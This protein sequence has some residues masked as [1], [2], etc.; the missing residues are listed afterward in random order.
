MTDPRRAIPR[1]DALL[2]APEFVD[3]AGRLGSTA[4]KSAIRSAQEQARSGLID[5]TEVTV[6]A[7]AILDKYTSSRPVLNATGVV[8]HTNLGRAPLSASAVAAVVAAAGYTDLE[9]DLAT[10]TRTPR[11]EAVRR[12]LLAA[13]PAAEDALVVNNGAAALV[14]A[15]TAL[16]DRVVV[17]RGELVEI[18][19]GFRIADLITS[20]GARLVEVG[21]TNKTSLADYVG[22]VTEGAR[23][24]VLKVHPS[25][26]RIEGF[27]AAAGVEELATLGPPV[28]V[29]IG[30]GLL[31]PD[32][33]LPEEPTAQG[34]LAAG[35]ALV[36]CSGDKLLGGPQSGLIFGRADLIGR[37][38][39]HPLARALRVDKLTLAALEA[40]LTAEPTPVTAAR[41]AATDDLRAR[42][43]ALLDAV[44][45]PVIEVVPSVGR[46]GGGGAPGVDLPGFALAL[47]EAVALPLRAGTPAVLARV[48]KGH[49]LVDL[50]CVPPESDAILALALRRA[51]GGAASTARADDPTTGAP[52]PTTRS[53]EPTTRTSEAGR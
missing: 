8:V 34:A 27:T 1:T 2:A 3:A 22:G 6:F 19:D 32:P 9:L 11:G 4:V 26:Y 50:R 10:N 24:V 13:V 38:R 37:L 20:T 40:T 48:E 49:C 46:V 42:T 28:V 36:I 25:N 51:L 23:S 39:R 29:D 30:S 35:A 44:A 43:H 16:A 45:H 17:S 12:A 52:V 5:P 18:G 7:L 47:P 53:A 31:T 41:T 14:L 21:A 33:N 15:V